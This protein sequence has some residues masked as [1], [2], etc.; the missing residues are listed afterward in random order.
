[1][2]HTPALNK[3]LAAVPGKLVPEQRMPALVHYIQVAPDKPQADLQR[4]KGSATANQNQTQSELQPERLKRLQV[5][6]LLTKVFSSY[7]S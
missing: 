4:K 5:E 2:E 6:R 1:V 3:P 7:N